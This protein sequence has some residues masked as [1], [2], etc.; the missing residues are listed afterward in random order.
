M[1]ASSITKIEEKLLETISDLEFLK[2]DL[3][4]VS[5]INSMD[6]EDMILIEKIAESI[7]TRRSLIDLLLYKHGLRQDQD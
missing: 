3:D 4:K 1:T 7:K 6:A 2:E 5:D